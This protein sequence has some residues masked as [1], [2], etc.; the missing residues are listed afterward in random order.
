LARKSEPVLVVGLGRFGT[1][2]ARELARNGN[3]VLAVDASESQVQRLSGMIADIVVADGTDIQALEELGAADFHTAV[4]A[5]GNLEASTL[6]TSNLAQLGVE[7]IWAKALSKQ[8][9]L[10][11]ERVGAHHVVQPE[12]DM[13]QR[14]AHLVSGEVLDY[15]RVAE[16][17]VIAKTKPPRFLV[18]VPLGQSNLRKEHRITVIAVKPEG[19]PMFTHADS[20]TH[21]AYGDEILVMGTTKDVTRFAALA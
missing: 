9:A 18:G 13:G 11:L 20:Q 17:W 4:V 8:H 5:V 14:I 21:L 7:R 2:L 10:I 3:E 16:N 15:L 1:A 12:H 19:G 6:A